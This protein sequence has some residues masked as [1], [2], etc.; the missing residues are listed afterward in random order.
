[1]VIH[2]NE[3]SQEADAYFVNKDTGDIEY[4]NYEQYYSDCMFFT[5]LLSYLK[6]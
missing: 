5:I 6:K 3:E 1:M 2:P 4:K